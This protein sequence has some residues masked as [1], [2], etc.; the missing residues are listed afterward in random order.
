ML[1]KRPLF[2]TEL[3]ILFCFPQRPPSYSQDVHKLL[4]VSWG[5][6]FC[7]VIVHGF[8][9]VFSQDYPH[10]DNFLHTPGGLFGVII[11][12]ISWDVNNLFKCSKL[13]SFF[14]NIN[15]QIKR[16]RVDNFF[17]MWRDVSCSQVIH[18]RAVEKYNLH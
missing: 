15:S 6:S 7:I 10:V 12:R 14:F 5:C 1:V 4:T 8:C 2:F 13:L 17:K 18:K 11:H 16:S 3:R 9:L